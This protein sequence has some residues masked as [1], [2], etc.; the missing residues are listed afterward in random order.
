MKF[1]EKYGPWA[2][3]TGASSGI[4]REFCIQLAEMGLKL[5]LVARSRDKLEGLA[6]ELDT[7]CIVVVSDLSKPDF[8]DPMLEG[9]GDRDVGLVVNNAGFTVTGHVAD[10]PLDRQLMMVDLNCRAPMALAKVFGERLKARG[11]GG[12]IITA[13]TMGFHSAELWAGYNATKGFDLLLA[14]GMAAELEPHG[15]DVMA[16]CPGGTY[17]GFAAAGGIDLDAQPAWMKLFLMEVS[18]VVREALS[19]LGRR[20]TV[21]AGLLN[22]L[23]AF[24]FRFLP[25]RMATWILGRIVHQLAH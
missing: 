19:K 11:R 23:N 4:G 10:A 2:L 22:K 6:N 13:S 18:P 24:S 17:T 7:E 20:R 14:E 21:V 16:L 8:L 15:V 12:M 1:D 25:R 9:I 3:V 5:I